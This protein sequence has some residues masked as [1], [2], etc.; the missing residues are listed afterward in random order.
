MSSEKLDALVKDLS[1]RGTKK[2]MIIRNDTVVCNWFA[3]GYEDSI[4]GHYTA[5]LAKS[6]VSGMSLLTA[7]E[8]GLLHPE[9][10]ACHFIP[11]WKDDYVKS[12]ITIRQLAGHTSGI[13]D[14]EVSSEEAEEMRSKGLHTHMDLPGWKGQFW[15]KEPDPFSVSRDSAPVLYKPGQKYMYSNPGIAMLN[16]AVTAAISNSQQKD[17]RSYLQERIFRPIGIEDREYSV[18]YGTTYN[19]EGLPLVAGWGGGGFTANA[20]ARI[21][22]LM[23]RQGNW[24]GKQLIDS[25]LVAEAVR[26]EP[27]N[28]K[29]FYTDKENSDNPFLATTLGLVQQPRRYLEIPAPGCICRCRSP[30]PA[31]CW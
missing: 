24:Q 30:E 25:S 5:S 16:Y 17:I 14:A 19:L 29:E 10:A 9:E 23:L 28:N 1:A 20:V 21:G 15:R 2:L 3:E 13:E 4:R 8:D 6:I 22:R 7:M 27:A 11:E 18:G 26:F 12:K 31:I